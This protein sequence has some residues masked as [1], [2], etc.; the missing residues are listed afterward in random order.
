M[1]PDSK[2]A[3]LLLF[4]GDCGVCTRTAEL[5]EGM[6]AAHNFSIRPYRGFTEDELR[7]FGLSYEK[8]S[9]RAYA[10]SPSGKVYGGAFAAN[11]FFFKRF[12]WS[13]LVVLIYALP[14]LLLAELAG[15][16]LVAKN[17]YRISRWLG[18]EACRIK[19]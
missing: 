15:Y 3:A 18:L 11:Y 16:Y 5:M 19:F 10:I 9:K 14:P 8:C 1:K 4:D 2:K 6:D 17:R 13:L 7:R 12:P